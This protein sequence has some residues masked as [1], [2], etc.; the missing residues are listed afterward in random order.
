M[1]HDIYAVILQTNIRRLVCCETKTYTN[2]SLFDIKIL[3]KWT[4]FNHVMSYIGSRCGIYATESE[5][6]AGT[7]SFVS[8]CAGSFLAAHR[9]VRE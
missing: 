3:M 9:A 7:V 6:G 4:N 8:I 1:L 2:V 5:V